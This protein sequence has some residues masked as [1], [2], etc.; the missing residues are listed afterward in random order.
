M[1]VANSQRGAIT[2]ATYSRAEDLDRCIGNIVR[3]RGAEEIPLIIIHQQGIPEVATTIQKWRHE[4]QILVETE[5]Q[6]KSPLENINLNGLLGK[7]I[8]FTWL[9]SDWCLGVEDDVQI[10][11]DSVMFI[12]EMYQKYNKN[13]F[14]R[15]VNLGSKKP[16]N[17]EEIG[18]YNRISFGLHGQAS[19]ITKK[20]WNH[21]DVSKLRSNSN[22]AGLDAMMEHFTKTGFMCTPYN[23][24]YLDNGWNG[25]HSSP[26]PNNLHYRLI[27]ESFYNNQVSPPETYTRKKFENSW[28]QDSIEFSIIKVMPTLIFNKL[29]HFRFLLTNRIKVRRQ[30]FKTL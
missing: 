19:M 16:F 27:R 30:A 14:F 17:M 24:R 7:E 8:A 23:S 3:A 5:A 4:I 12:K 21:F 15:G 1:K 18:T 22:S 20:T 28:R 13:L 6:G 26:D 29:A 11:A 25:T 2:V 9:R 10:S